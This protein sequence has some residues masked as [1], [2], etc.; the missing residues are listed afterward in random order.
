MTQAACGVP[1]DRNKSKARMNS[2]SRIGLDLFLFENFFR[3]KRGGVFV[4]ATAQSNG[5]FS[6]T[7]LFERVM[8]KRLLRGA[9]R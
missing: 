6:E 7:L 3:G 1:S 2:F 4:D 5:Q 9:G 8:R